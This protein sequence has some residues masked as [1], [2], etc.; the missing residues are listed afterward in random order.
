MQTLV[1]AALHPKITAGIADVPAGC[2]LNGPEA[3]RAPGWPMWYWATQGK[4]E[5]R[6][7]SASRYYDVVNFAS[8]IKV[9]IL[10]GL[11]LVDIACPAPG[12]FTVANQLKGRREV[13]IMPQ[14]GHGGDHGPY[15]R[16]AEE[17]L[18]ALK[19]GQAP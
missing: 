17:W 1:T 18:N 7:R 5:K 16:R 9:P 2:D 3:G 19:N 13:V 6:V 15:Y 11:G 14:T 10:I 8:R 12:V 4:D